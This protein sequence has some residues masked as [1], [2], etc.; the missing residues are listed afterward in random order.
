M[1]DDVKKLSEKHIIEDLWKKRATEA[2]ESYVCP[3]YDF[4]IL[5]HKWDI[6]PCCRLTDEDSIGNLFET[7]PDEIRV[8]KKN[9]YKCKRCIASKQHYIAHSHTEFKF[10]IEPP[11]RV[12]IPKLYY[13]T[14]KGFSEALVMRVGHIDENSGQ[15]YGE[16]NFP[17]KPINVR[18]DPTEGEYCI[19]D[20]LSVFSGNGTVN[21]SR[22]NAFVQDNTFYF[23][24]F[25]PQILFKDINSNKLVIS[26][27]IHAFKNPML[28]N[29]I[30]KLKEYSGKNI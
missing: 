7:N 11:K 8:K 14:G 4:I 24:N 15:F 22:T 9:L 21:Y 23:D 2:P 25:D 12:K 10:S 13:D 19:L 6:V 3:Q 28:L 18:F 16:Y 1:P 20:N 17:E 30:Q 29:S 5:D 27:R 26:A